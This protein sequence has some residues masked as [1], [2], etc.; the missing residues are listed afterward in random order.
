MAEHLNLPALHFTWGHLD[1]RGWLVFAAA[2]GSP[3]RGLS[4]D[5]AITHAASIRRD[6]PD[7]AAG[8]DACVRCIRAAEGG[9]GYAR[10]FDLPPG[11]GWRSVVRPAPPPPTA[12]LEPLF[13]P[14]EQREGWETDH[15][16]IYDFLA[17]GGHPEAVPIREWIEAWY[18]CL[19]PTKRPSIRGVL[20]G[21]AFVNAYF[22][23]RLLAMLH[24]LGC[25]VQVEPDDFGP[26]HVPDFRAVRDGH[27]FVVE[28]TV[29]S[30]R[31]VA[32]QRN[33]DKV[34]KDLREMIRE[35]FDG[36]A[37]SDLWLEASGELGDTLSRSKV[38]PIVEL[39]RSSNPEIVAL[40]VQR[41]EPLSCAIE[42]G[43]WRLVA[44]L[45]PWPQGV[46][47]GVYS[48][49]A[50]TTRGGSEDL[51]ACRF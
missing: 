14:M 46:A 32:R 49:I 4:V 28:A 18:G 9:D 37:H 30:S 24:A 5:D 40:A 43:E 21:D 45:R 2:E 17:R 38:E 41:G 7:A 6:F 3:A 31:T 26:H 11:D 29:C 44:E 22:E 33:E 34:W 48:G 20:S 23:L 47:M 1:G 15:E 27:S 13:P 42:H 25:E 51:G 12:G 16:R 19:P 35:A 10:V 50:R 39:M 36:P 8:I